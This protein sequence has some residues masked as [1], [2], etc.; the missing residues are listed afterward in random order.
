MCCHV[1]QVQLTNGNLGNA[2]ADG[3]RPNGLTPLIDML[4][5]LEEGNDA[6]LGDG[7]KETRGTDERL[8]GSTKG[9]EEGPS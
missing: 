6:V 9:R 8:Q 2:E 1:E 3:N 4:K 5:G 7:L